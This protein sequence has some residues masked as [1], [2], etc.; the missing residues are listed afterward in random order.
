MSRAHSRDRHPKVAGNSSIYHQRPDIKPE[1]PIR[2]AEMT[3]YNKITGRPIRATAGKVRQDTD[4]VDSGLLEEDDLP[5]LTS[6]DGDVEDDAEQRRRA[7]KKARKRKRSPSPPSP[8]L[9]PIIRDQEAEQLTDNEL[10][11]AFHRRS[12]KK[13]PISLQFN[14]PLGFHGPLFVKLDNALLQANSEAKLHEMQVVKTKK[15]RR[16]SSS[17]TQVEAEVNYKGF[18]DLPPE[19]RN[20]IYRYLFT[21]KDKD[22][23]IPASK[24]GDKLCRSSQFLRTCKLVHDEG[25]SVLYGENTFRLARHFSTRGPFWEPVPREIGYQDVLHFLKMI[26]PEN[27]QYL[28]DIELDFDDA[29]PRD[30]PYISSNEKRRYLNDE[31]LINCLRIL[32]A[33]KLRTIVLRF[34]GRRQ[35]VKSDV[36]FLGYLDQIKADEVSKPVESWHFLPKIGYLVWDDLKKAM[37]RKKKLYEK[38]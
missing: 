32:R 9:A 34:Y 12:S 21:S 17:P 31:Y 28:R 23:R 26:G 25:C 14:V 2:T 37:T 20:S 16:A 5:W 19:L 36:T 18:S 33:A 6:D 13:P 3:Q 38:K 11:G 15:T 27:L 29:L 22:I 4:F 30:T 7:S 1:G 35:I 10:G 8:C 24:G